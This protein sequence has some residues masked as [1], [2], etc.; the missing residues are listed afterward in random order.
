VITAD[1][2]TLLSE[3]LDVPVYPGAVPKLGSFPAV[4]YEEQD[5]EEVYTFDGFSGLTYAVYDVVSMAHKLAT[6]DE[7]A[8]SVESI[9]QG[10]KGTVG[11][12][13]IHSVV[14][15]SQDKVREALSDEVPIWIITQT[16]EITHSPA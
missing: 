9:L 15:T 4:V 2:Y 7:I 8:S 6:A 10:Y 3:D 11:N 13:M 14:K 16:Y 5:V 12:T 1:L